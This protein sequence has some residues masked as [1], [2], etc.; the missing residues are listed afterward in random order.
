MP[1]WE[2]T[3]KATEVHPLHFAGEVGWAH[4]MAAGDLKAEAEIWAEGGTASWGILKTPQQQLLCC[5]PSTLFRAGRAH[6]G[7]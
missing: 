4:G 1:W 2:I 6:W 7:S 5:V 3:S